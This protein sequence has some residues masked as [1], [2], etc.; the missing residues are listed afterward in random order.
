MANAG[1]H[2]GC[3]SVA[4]VCLRLVWDSDR[5]TSLPLRG[6]ECFHCSHGADDHIFPFWCL[7]VPG[8]FQIPARDW[9]EQHL[10]EKER[11]WGR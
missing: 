7:S 5:G 1:G 10:I 8:H 11:G 9:E 4:V 6:S 3:S 2:S